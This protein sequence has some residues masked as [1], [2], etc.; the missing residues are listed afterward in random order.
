MTTKSKGKKKRAGGSHNSDLGKPAF[1]NAYGFAIVTGLFF[2]V[3]WSGQFLAQ[4]VVQESD[5]RIEAKLDRLLEER[6]L[7]PDEISRE[8][9]EAL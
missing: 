2:L 1:A 9:N 4:M 8:V 5:E 6:G 7:D 3:S